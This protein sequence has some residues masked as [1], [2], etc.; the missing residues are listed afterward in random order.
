MMLLSP[1]NAA[2]YLAGRGVLH[3]RETVREVR[4]LSGGVSGTV[5]LVE[6]V[7]QASRD[8]QSAG[9]SP[10]PYRR[11]VAK[12]ARER[13]DVADEWTADPRRILVEQRAV[14]ALRPF[15]DVNVPTFHH[16]DPDD[17]ILVMEAAPETSV[18]WRDELLAGRA[19]TWIA[20]AAGELMAT[21]HLVGR[22]RP[23]LRARFADKQFLDVLR[24]RPFHERLMAVHPDLAG[25]V[26][27]AAARLRT[28]AATLV[29]GDYSPKNILAVPAGKALAHAGGGES[30]GMGATQDGAVAAPPAIQPRR[31]ILLDFEVAHWGEPAY[32]A[33][34][35]LGHLCLKAVAAPNRRALLLENA[36]DLWRAY[37]AK[38]ADAG[39]DPARPDTVAASEAET[40]RQ[41]LVLMLAR[42]D[43]TSRVGY[44]SPSQ[45]AAV[46]VMC[47]TLLPA[48]P[49]TIDDLLDAVH[50][51]AAAGPQ[52]A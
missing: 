11:L 3:D 25:P 29:H 15:A 50:D 19:E 36:A 8:G 49:T 34:F 33:G 37:A 22:R 24:L 13:L 42:V 46:R 5:L 48:P 10:A 44:L 35:C 16:L 14:A 41:T 2:D 28:T 7:R 32:D 12:Q 30:G 23:D 43:G 9:T 27:A 4:V 51:H 39:E 6:T 40:V 38:L 26:G 47:R 1:A 31:I 17:C 21:L 18:N 20:V 45:Q 52:Q